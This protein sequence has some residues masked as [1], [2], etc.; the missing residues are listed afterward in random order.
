MATLGKSWP[1]SLCGYD[2]CGYDSC[3]YDSCGYDSCGD[4]TGDLGEFNG[5]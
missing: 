5:E 3:G 2:S 1:T 4:K